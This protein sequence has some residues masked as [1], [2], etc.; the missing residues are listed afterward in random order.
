MSDDMYA[1]D[2]IELLKQSGIDFTQNEKRG[3]D[4]QDF[5]E[6]LMTSGVILNDEVQLRLLS[7]Q[8]Q[9]LGPACET[10]VRVAGLLDH[11][12]QQLRLWLPAEAGDLPAVAGH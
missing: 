1:Q 12:P 7:V 2:S 6:V 10:A 4:V 5:G 11:L 9:Y 8:A 3:I